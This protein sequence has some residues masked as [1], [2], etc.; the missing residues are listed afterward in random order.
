MGGTGDLRQ[1]VA[2]HTGDPAN[3]GGGTTEN[4]DW[5]GTTFAV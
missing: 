5:R 2:S 1:I 3:T 4:P